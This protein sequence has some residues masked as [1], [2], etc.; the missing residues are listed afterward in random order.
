MI[1]NVMVDMTNGWQ[2]ISSDGNITKTVTLTNDSRN[3]KVEYNL[4][5]AGG[6]QSLFVRNGLSPNLW[7]LVVEGQKRLGDLDDSGSVITLVNTAYVDTVTA[8]IRYS[9]DGNSASFVASAVDNDSPGTNYFTRTMR[10]Q[11]QTHQVEVSGTDNFIFT[12]ELGI[13]PSDW[14]GDGIP[15]IVE[16]GH[17]FLDPA[18]E[19][20]ADGDED[21]DGVSNE[22]EW[23]ANTDMNNSNDFPRVVNPSVS[24]GDI[25]VEIDT[26]SDRVYKIWYTDEELVGSPTW[27]L[28]TNSVV[29]GSGGTI[30]FVDDGSET[31]PSPSDV[32]K[33]FYRSEVELAE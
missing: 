29:E 31:A 27:I 6:S 33:R 13:V 22:D 23:I 21:G 30:P 20:D 9:G 16:D 14:D 10:N 28:I 19:L 11:A 17:V 8:S 18:N 24:G 4:D 3:L 15:N 5:T 7:N 2:L 32:P 12:F 25:T 26:K 1:N